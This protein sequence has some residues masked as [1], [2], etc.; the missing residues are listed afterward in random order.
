MTVAINKKE[1]TTLEMKTAQ[2]MNDVGSVN[3]PIEKILQ[4]DYTVSKV[5][6]PERFSLDCNNS[7][8]SGISINIIFNII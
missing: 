6:L 1:I 2:F 7:I 5:A 8:P 4:T 3:D